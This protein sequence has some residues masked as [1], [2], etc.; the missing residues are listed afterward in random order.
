MLLLQNNFDTTN[1]YAEAIYYFINK[2]ESRGYTSVPV[3]YAILNEDELNPMLLAY[4][5]KSF[6]ESWDINNEDENAY[7]ESFVNE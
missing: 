1:S 7:W 3:D 5:E 4:A 2:S 6:A